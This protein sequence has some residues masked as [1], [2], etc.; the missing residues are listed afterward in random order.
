MTDATEQPAGADR[1]KPVSDVIAHDA[2]L[3][4]V[5]GRL[6]GFIRTRV[7]SPADAEDVVQDVLVRLLEEP[8][9]EVQNIAA[10][11]FT[12]AR[13][14]IIDRHRRRRGGTQD[15]A[16]ADA[17]AAARDEQASASAE[18]ARCIE[19]LMAR[20]DPADRALL[21]RVDL[22]GESQ[23]AIAGELGVSGS[24]IKS[25]VQRARARLLQELTRCCAIERDSRGLPVEYR[26]NDGGACECDR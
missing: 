2:H 21:E 4:E 20:L 17:A 7:P 16:D 1:V 15:L 11:L 14:A 13:R 26:Q 25:R 9:G 24:T 23:A 18:L 10:W 19:P 6:R 3:D 5:I 12:V 8:P 22:A